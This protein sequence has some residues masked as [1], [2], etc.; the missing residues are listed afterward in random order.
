MAMKN[1][2]IGRAVREIGAFVRTRRRQAGVTQEQL[3]ERCGIVRR[4]VVSLEAGEGGT[5][6]T[7]LAVLAE[8]GCL[9]EATAP[10]RLPATEEPAARKPVR[11]PDSP[12][13]AAG[14]GN[15]W[16]LDDHAVL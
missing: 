8:L 16:V 2:E 12:Q 10:F 5:V 9:G 3:A 14:G 15:P 7:L 13:A 1:E 6:G 11:P 4:T